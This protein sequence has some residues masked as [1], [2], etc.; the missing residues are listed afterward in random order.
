MR[1]STVVFLVL[2]RLAIGWHF[3]FEGLQKLH[4]IYVGPTTTNKPFSSAGYLR[5]ANGPLG[6]VFRWGVGDPDDEALAL[7]TVQPVP[8]GEDPAGYKRRLR[9]PELLRQRWQAYV[10]RMARFYGLD[11]RQQR[12][13]EAKLEQAE[14]AA[15]DWL[16]NDKDKKEVV[17]RYPSGEVK[18]AETVAERVADYRAKVEKLRDVE[19]RKLPVFGADVEG[20]RLRQLKAEVAEMRSAL[21]ADL[22]RQ[23]EALKAS[24]DEVPNKKQKERGAVPPGDEGR[25]LRWIDLLTSWGLTAIGACLLAGFLARPACVLGALFL[26]AVNLSHPALP[27]VPAPPQSEGNYL[28]VSKNVIEMLALCALAT[29]PC[30]RWF[31][32]DAIFHGIW[33]LIRGRRDT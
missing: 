28:F 30:G 16:L 12:L 18:K 33:A 11:G 8:E 24:L 17:K 29:V 15:V 20:A 3:L 9:T 4:S 13:A 23:T 26:L 1:R 19:A 27:W 32:L 10:D 5:E 22:N 31:G 2:L 21:L 25:V 14:T 7:L 6:N